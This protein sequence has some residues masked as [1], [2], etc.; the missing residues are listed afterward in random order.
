MEFQIYTENE[1]RQFI[2]VLNTFKF[3]IKIKVD[4]IFKDRSMPL[5]RYYHL[6]KKMLAD[7]IGLSPSETH[8]LL[9]KE[10]ALIEEVVEDGKDK[11]IVESSAGMNVVRFLKYLEDI[12]RWSLVIH[13]LYLPEPN[14]II[15]DT[16]ELKLKVI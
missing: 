9:L 12:K 15:D 5:N 11:S 4:N 1:R 8:N 13:G 3:P 2:D 6:I 10:F 16:N 14:E 7:H